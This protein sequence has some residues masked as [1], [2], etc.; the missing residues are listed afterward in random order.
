MVAPSWK[1]RGINEGY[2]KLVVSVVVTA[3]VGNVV[4]GCVGAMMV[5]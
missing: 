3:V 1:Y 2:R 5:V 4:D